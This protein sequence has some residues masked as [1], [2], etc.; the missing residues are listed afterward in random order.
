MEVQ[1]KLKTPFLVI[2]MLAAGLSS[3]AAQT[4]LPGCVPVTLDPSGSQLHSGLVVD[5]QDHILVT[6]FD[7]T[8]T[9]TRILL[10]GFDRLGGRL[11]PVTVGS[12][13]PLTRKSRPDLSVNYNGV[14]LLTWADGVW[15][16]SYIF[17]R[18]FSMDGSARETNARPDAVAR[19]M[20]G[21]EPSAGI[22]S[23]GVAYVVWQD[24]TADGLDVF[25]ARFLAADSLGYGAQDTATHQW[26]G[27]HRLNT[28]VNGDQLDPDIAVDRKGN[29]VVAWRDL[30][31]DST[32]I[33]FMVFDRLG[34]ELYN[35]LLQPADSSR[36]TA[37]SPPSVIASEFLSRSSRFII[38]WVEVNGAEVPQLKAISIELQTFRAPY[39]AT[40]DSVQTILDASPEVILDQPSLSGNENGD[41]AL[42]WLRESNGAGSAWSYVFNLE[43]GILE[44]GRQ[45]LISPEGMDAIEPAAAVRLDGTFAAVWGA[46]DHG[47]ADLWMQNFSAGGIIQDP[48]H[49]SPAGGSGELAGAAAL[50]GHADQSYSLF[51]EGESGGEVT[52]IRHL[53]FSS[54]DRPAGSVQVLEPAAAAQRKPAAALSGGGRFAVGWQESGSSGYRVRAS[55][56]NAD[57]TV[58]NPGLILEE[59]SQVLLDGLTL[60]FG[61]NGA[62]SAAWE[63]WSPLGSSP[64][65]VLGHW[66]SL[67]VRT[68]SVRSVAGVAR[69]GGRFASL[70]A[71][72]A[73]YQMLVW[74]QGAV[75]GL[76]ARIKAQVFGPTGTPVSSELTVSE[77]VAEFLGS[78]GRPLAVASSLTGR[79]LVVWQEFFG[80]RQRLYYRLYSE[81]GDSLELPQGLGYRGVFNG[82]A[83]TGVT[84]GNTNPAVAVDNRGDHLVLWVEKEMGGVARLLGCKID[85]LGAPRGSTFQVPGVSMAALPCLS[86]LGPDRAVLAWN[87]TTGAS[88]RLFVQSL[89][90]TFYNLS[91]Q[92]ALSS[93]API[94]ARPVVH[95]TGNVV[96]SVTVDEA[97]NFSFGTLTAGDYS[98]RAELNGRQ[99]TLERSSFRLSGGEGG[100]VSLGRVKIMDGGPSGPSLP[101]AA[102]PLLYQNTPNP[103]NPSTTITFDLPAEW[104]AERVSLRVYDLRG[105][106]VKVLA[107]EDFQEGRHSVQW[108]GSDAQGRAVASGVYFYRMEAGGRSLVR[109]MILLK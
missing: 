74:R 108:D 49:V 31:P 68:G 64:E 107:D 1:K 29:S 24:E 5:H 23:S 80:D 53:D 13:Y 52:S 37:V 92:L 82:L 17:F 18:R 101:L 67:G 41:A 42:V 58:Q 30:N 91:G 90:I 12:I 84:A 16:A 96:D 40:P 79:F 14:A 35:Q 20:R 47:D 61:L 81:R 11:G 100:E 77:P 62:L 69:G 93:G 48:M 86:I 85:S 8:E 28:T 71:G 43:Q 97:G 88:T 45:G 95:I 104:N 105:A 87:D 6:W 44:S 57:R 25:G 4:P 103:F 3:A 98:L 65:L 89:K 7:S 26:V 22:D 27:T 19:R 60:T 73:G 66:D 76:N 15:P 94:S 46:G 75:K 39:T 51:W 83:A 33:R 102:Q 10:Q 38:S 36:V 56:F 59:S 55:L 21:S 32:G 63:R 109:K 34:H 2:L 50:V 54:D 9:S 106:L 99:L 72:P 70:A 78:T